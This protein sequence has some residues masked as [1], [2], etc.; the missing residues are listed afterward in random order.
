MKDGDQPMYAFMQGSKL[1]KTLD[2][3]CGDGSF[4]EGLFSESLD[5]KSYLGLDSNKNAVALAQKK[6]L[7]VQHLDVDKGA[8]PFPDNA[9]DT[10]ILKD[11][12]EHVNDPQHLVTEARRC[13]KKNG[14]LF[15]STPSEWSQLLWDDYTHKRAFTLRALKQLVEDYG[16][17]VTKAANYRHTIQFKTSRLK[18]TGRLIFK[19][20]TG[21]D[22]LT[23]AY[24]V[25]ATPKNVD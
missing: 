4:A 18:Y 17:T 20:L 22:L 3:G 15:I 13:I 2:V 23:Q 7:N 5:R 16:F 8:L 6:G 11:V 12:L 19:F 14:T 25:Q 9:F 10:I 1:G 24:L 21:I